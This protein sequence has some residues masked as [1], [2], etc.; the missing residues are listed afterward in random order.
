MPIL[1]LCVCFVWQI[2]VRPTDITAA[3][4]T[5]IA[6]CAACERGASGA[7]T[8]KISLAWPGTFFC[9]FAALNSDTERV[10]ASQGEARRDQR[11]I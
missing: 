4:C 2:I 11:S 10:K 5:H 9:L 7:A 1:S 8:F 6:H 3:C